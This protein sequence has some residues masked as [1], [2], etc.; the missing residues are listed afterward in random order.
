MGLLPPLS[1]VSPPL[2]D[3]PL[4]H[5]LPGQDAAEVE[6]AQ[7]QRGEV[8]VQDELGHGAARGGGVLQAVAA[9]AG[10]E[11][12]VGDE[13]VRPDDG[14]LVEGVVVVE[15]GPRARHLSDDEN[16]KLSSFSKLNRPNASFVISRTKKINAG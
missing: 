12:H 9:E 7:V 5:G 14:V 1:V 8:P 10:G 6:A 2:H 16:N 15:T 4:Q 3:V 13:R 11:V